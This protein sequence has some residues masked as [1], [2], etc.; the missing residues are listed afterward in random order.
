ME[1]LRNINPVKVDKSKIVNLEKGKLPPQA[2]DMEEAILGALMLDSHC[3]DEL[4]NVF[5]SE[6]VFYKD[7]HRFVFRAIKSLADKSSQIDLLTVSAELKAQGILELAGGDFF[8]IQLTQK[9]SSGAHLE[10]WARIVMQQ[11]MRRK[12]IAVC[13]EVI[14]Y[15]YDDTVDVFDMMDKIDTETAMIH[16]VI[17]KGKSDMTFAT[18]LDVVE[19][20]VERL[21]SLKEGEV[22]GVTTGFEKLDRHFGGWQPTDLIVLG[23]RPGAGK[24]ALTINMM[25]SAAKVGHPVGFISMEMSTVQLA[26]RAVAV[27]SNYHL[28]QLTK[29]GFEKTEYFVGLRALIDKMKSL[30][31]HIDE[32]PA[33]TISEIKRKARLLKRK[34][35]IK[36]LIVDYIQ[37]T[38]GDGDVRIRVG[39]A[40]QGLKALA[41]EL[42]IPVI[43]ISGLSR[44]ADKAH[45]PMLAH[46]KESG[47]IEADAD[48]VAFLYRAAYYGKEVDT[49]VID[50]DCNTEF[51]VAK[52]RNGGLGTIGLFFDENKTKFMDREPRKEFSDVIPIGNPDEAFSITDMS[53]NADKDWFDKDED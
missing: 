15:A 37:L 51:I 25:I 7:Q 5:S 22:T 19:K 20:N 6:E 26:T 2:L 47:D 41:K 42:Q 38:G 34:F 8:L 10:F 50:E 16:D 3:V 31:I 36:E 12:M 52:Y 17:N 43:A 18:A 49:E 53:T 14:E 1:N 4:F 30:P 13:S 35:D 48:I 27:N 40:S 9:I 44:E 29:K 33:L 28:N 39:K 21:S 45:R 32:R 11:Y 24:T 46:L 23:A